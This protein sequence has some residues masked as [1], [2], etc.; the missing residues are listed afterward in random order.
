MDG[1]RLAA[2][3][4]SLLLV[5]TALAVPAT[6]NTLVRGSPELSVTSPTGPVQASQA[7]TLSL[8]LTNEGDLSQG[9]PQNPQYEE[10]VT[11]AR[12]VRVEVIESGID[13]PVDVRTGAQ[14]LGRLPSGET[15]PLEY[16][17]E[18]GQA[19]P[20]TYRVPVRVEYTYTVAINY[21][22]FEQPEFST[23]TETVRTSVRLRVEAR[24]QFE[25]TTN[26]TDGLF[27]GDTD[28]LALTVENVGTRTADDARLS[29]TAGATELFFG[30]TA[31][32]QRSTGLFVG[33]LGPG[34]SRQVAVRVGA[35]GDAVAGSYPVETT[36]VYENAN[37]VT[38]RAD[39]ASVG[40]T[41]GA[42]RRFALRN[43]ATE[44]LRVG[45]GEARITADLANMGEGTARQVAVRI[46]GG[47]DSSV[48]PTNGESAVGDL[49]PGESAPVSFTV[50]VAEDAEPG[51]NSFAFA[52]E[53]ENAA[54]DVLRAEPVRR[55]LTIDPQRDPFRVT[56]VSADVSPGGSGTLDVTLRY[57]G[58]E[59]ASAVNARFFATDPLSSADDGAFLGRVQPGDEVTAT[60]GVSA[61][62]S[63]LVKTYDSSVEVRYDEPDGDTRFTDGLP[64]GVPV[65]AS[66]GGLPFLPLGVV[67]LVVLG[68]GAYVLV[69][70]RR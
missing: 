35:N 47:Q 52:V 56:N 63:A 70:R 61:G 39:P 44:R 21:D 51:T 49:G 28:R 43:L 68:G 53:Y 50:A 38:E 66:D 15:A 32:P 16:E 4:V 5:S 60:F 34:E 6:A 13:A 69:R 7:T 2:L 65:T 59:P 57:V 48:T 14:T 30:P 22:Q 23:T 27:A 31:N 10:Q 17:L 64:V 62:G 9:D 41:V 3:V 54:G 36:V 40:V 12:N 11:T 42:E 45:E 19:E 29:L 67:G 24:P 25:V 18:V 8:S 55:A 37:G 46:R 26:G 1:R 33:D 58:D 20:G